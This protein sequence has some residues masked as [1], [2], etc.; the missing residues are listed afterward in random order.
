MTL[1]EL[2]IVIE[3]FS[4]DHAMIETTL[5]GTDEE[6]D[7]IQPSSGS[8]MWYWV[9][10]SAVTDTSVTYSFNIA[11]MDVLNPDKDNVRDVLSDTHGLATQFLAYMDYYQQVND[12]H[13][14]RQGAITPF[15]EE[16]ESD[17]AGYNIN[18]TIETKLIYDK[19]AIPI[20]SAITTEDGLVIETEDEQIM[21]LG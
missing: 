5:F 9:D 6:I 3:D 18:V 14:L 8:L 7:N 11:F 21:I 19:C 12:F 2:I 4:L 20:F 17:Y 1:N 10:S 16:W 15:S 13:I